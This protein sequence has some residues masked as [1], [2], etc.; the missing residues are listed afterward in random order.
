MEEVIPVKIADLQKENQEL[1][2]KNKQLKRFI[3]IGKILSLERDIDQLLPLLM[4]E[5]SKSLD[6]LEIENYIS[7]FKEKNAIILKTTSRFAL[8]FGFST[9]LKNLKQQLHWRLRRNA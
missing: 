4:T 8:E 5:I 6:T 1:R 2:I 7:E 3:E 9:E